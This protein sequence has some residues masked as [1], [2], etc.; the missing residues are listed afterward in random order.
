[1]KA[2]TFV[3][4][5]ATKVSVKQQELC[6]SR[7][8]LLMFFQMTVSWQDSLRDYSVHQESHESCYFFSESRDTCIV[9]FLLSRDVLI[10]VQVGFS[11]FFSSFLHPFFPFQ[12]PT[13]PAVHEI[14]MTWRTSR[15]SRRFLPFHQRQLY[16]RRNLQTTYKLRA[17]QDILEMLVICQ[18]QHG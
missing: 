16:L 6:F 5:M 13:F 10:T 9:S 14:L 8:D 3:H 18:K 17:F 15:M 1:M 7:L 12:V 4:L 11:I 2:N